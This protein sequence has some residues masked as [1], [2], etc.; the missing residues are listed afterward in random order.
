L[1]L[2]AAALTACGGG[3][4]TST[5]PAPVPTPD[6]VVSLARAQDSKTFT[7]PVEVALAPL[8]NSFADTDR[9]V[10][11]LDGAAYRIEVPKQW[12]G[13]L[14]MWA[15]GYWGAPTLYI[16]NPWFRR[17][18]LQNGYAWAVSSYTRNGYDVNVGVEDTNR[19]AAEFQKIA[20]ARGRSLTAPRRIYIAGVSMGG[21][22][23]AAAV[24][25]EIVRDA[26]NQLRYDGA[27]SVCGSVN[28]LDWY[29]YMA[30][31]QLAMQ[32]LLGYPAEAF[33]SQTYVQNKA[34]MQALVNDSVNR[35]DL[36]NPGVSKLYSLMEQL[37]GGKRP[38]YREGWNDIYHHNI[39]FGLMNGQTNLDGVLALNGLDTRSI[40]YG[41][42]AGVS[43]DAETRQFND[44]IRRVTPDANANP[45]QPKGLRWVPI[46]AGQLTAPVMTMQT[47]GDLTVPIEVQVRYRQRAG[48]QGQGERLT[49]RLFRDVGHCAF[50]NAEIATAFDDLVAWT[51]QGRRPTGD[52]LLDAR[53]WSAPDAGCLHTDN[54]SSTE[55][56]ADPTKRAKAQAAYPACPVR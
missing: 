41:F 5:S 31:Y 47:L 16:E 22:V 17:H 30:A 3:G 32:S 34:A 33:P 10:G 26:R 49:Q 2:C 56:R 38:F 29:N 14:V 27:L 42:S 4:G 15:R 25:A 1:L 13:K 9:W 45:V 48:S 23:A 21:H 20:A 8:D 12:N 44:T 50:T 52:D 35:G 40:Q 7:A 36:S 54:R 55:D 53:V 43:T 28:G 19:L 18:L 11:I 51:E 24:E 37:S 39:L 6:P 46:V